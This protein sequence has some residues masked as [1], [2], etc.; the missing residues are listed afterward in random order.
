MAT[1]A[2][3]GVTKL[4]TGQAQ[5]EQTINEAFD[6]FDAALRT[7]GGPTDSSLNTSV[8]AF[9]ALDEP[10][11]MRFDSV[12]LNHLADNNTVTQV[13]GKIRG[14]AQFTAAN[15]EFLSVA[16]N[17]DLST[18]DVAFTVASWVYLDSK[19]TTRD[20]F[21]KWGAAGQR[22]Y[23]L[24]YDQ[25]VD[26]FIF[27]VTADGTTAVSVTA[28]TF[29]SPSTATW[30]FVVCYHD[31]TGN[32]IG[33]SVNN[34]AFNTTAHTTG[35]FNSTSAFHLGGRVSGPM[36]MDGRLDGVGFWKKLLSAAEITELYNSGAGL[37]YPF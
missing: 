22:E 14:A 13:A 31:P 2:N 27:F 37:D 18:G 10:L 17:T 33:I 3:L 35:V 28:S 5:K 21:S 19:T 11:G 16:D 32:L 25:A 8:K 20:I 1:T 30:Y 9:W 23:I 36:Y 6:A 26:R 34:G 24:T 15:S 12:G 4:E 29:G 7:A